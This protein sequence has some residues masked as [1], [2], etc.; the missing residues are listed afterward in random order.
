MAS[1][2]GTKKRV[3]L[4]HYPNTKAN[5]IVVGNYFVSIK[6]DGAD[7]PDPSDMTIYHGHTFSE[8]GVLKF[9]TSHEITLDY[10]PAL[11]SAPN[12]D[13]Q[14][15]LRIVILIAMDTYNELKNDP[16]FVRRVKKTFVL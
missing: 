2:A 6:G 3:R 9:E 4:V 15:Y 10:E 11:D 5:A 7:V 8:D 12:K 16:E 13:W 14:Q 1:R